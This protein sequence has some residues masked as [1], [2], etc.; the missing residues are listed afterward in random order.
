MA[1]Y[2]LVW[3]EWFD[4]AKEELLIQE[5]GQIT[6]L[7]RRGG[8][9]KLVARKWLR[10]QI[11]NNEVDRKCRNEDIEKIRS[12]WAKEKSKSRQEKFSEKD[13]ENLYEKNDMNEENLTKYCKQEILSLRWATKQW[14]NSIQ[15]LYLEKKEQ[16]D[17]GVVKYISAPVEKKRLMSEIYFAIKNGEYNINKACKLYSKDVKGTAEKA[18]TIK[19]GDMKPAMKY[20]VTSAKLNRIT[21]PFESENRII[22]L[23]VLKYNRSALTNDVMEELI[24]QNFDEFLGYGV[25]QIIKCLCG[26]VDGQEQ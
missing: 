22:I 3:Y 19:I 9:I 2:G 10:E 25:E 24:K 18:M 7:M 8:F 23:E 6:G 15:Q 4:S 16:F 12:R 21:S 11:A 20:H 14:S 17:Y 13:W 26:D 5:L 1:N